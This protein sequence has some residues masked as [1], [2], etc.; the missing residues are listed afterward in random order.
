ML[1][2]SERVN[3]CSTLHYETLI[4]MRILATFLFTISTLIL[5]AQT[6]TVEGYI[7]ENDNRG[8]ISS[9]S[10]TAEDIGT[11]VI[12]AKTRSDDSGYFSFEVPS[13]SKVRIYAV[14]DMYDVKRVETEVGSDKTFLKLMMGRSDGYT[15]EVTLAEKQNSP[16]QVV[17]AMTGTRIEVFN[18]TT[19]ES[20]MDLKE[21]DN[22]EFQLHLEKGNHYTILIR[23]TGFLSKR[24]EAKVDVEGCILCFD[25]VSKVGPGVSDNLTEGNAYGVL[26]ANIE[27]ERIFEGKT[28]EIP[29]LYYDLGKWN[30]KNAAQYKLEKVITL[31]KDNPSLTIELGSHTDSRGSDDQNLLL[32]KKR[33]AAAA[34]YLVHAG[35]ISRNRIMSQGYGE[36][37]LLNDCRNGVH[38][39]ENEHAENRRTELTIVGIMD[40]NR[41]KSLAQMKKE[42]YLEEE[43]LNPDDQDQIMA[44]DEE[45]LKRILKEKSDTRDQKDTT[46]PLQ[47]RKKTKNI[48]VVLLQSDRR[49]EE[50]HW[51]FEAHNNVEL[52]DSGFGKIY[53][54]IG[55]FENEQSAFE[56]RRKNILPHKRYKGN[57]VAS[58]KDGII[59]VIN[60]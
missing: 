9:A 25:G 21:H 24:M 22:P 13:H 11:E 34:E 3:C 45:E 37:A 57:F 36:K 43:I 58:L 15:F 23:K 29:N 51:I 54:M 59:A 50:D 8:Y 4:T 39:T 7:Y 19:R 44:R 31:M 6:T 56:Y 55:G 60:Q 46:N 26:L 38:C 20:V 28:V 2:E 33:A 27:M 18:N 17:D 5:H 12:L 49:L 48:K 47:G 42:E 32:S 40:M 30:I 16:D 1:L 35:G 52:M 10:I 53:Y 14:K 41:V